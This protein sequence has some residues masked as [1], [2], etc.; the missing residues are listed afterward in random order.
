MKHFTGNS[1]RDMLNNKQH[2][3]DVFDINLCLAMQR[4]GRP[5]NQAPEEHDLLLKHPVYETSII[6]AFFIFSRD[7]EFPILL[8]DI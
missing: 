1:Y 4:E 3:K 6:K 5:K 8:F 2:A 7:K